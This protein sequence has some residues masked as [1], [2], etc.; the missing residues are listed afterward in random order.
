MGSNG[1]AR[2]TAIGVDI[3]GTTTKAGIVTADGEIL[4]RV[5]RP[6]DPSAAT[7]GAIACVDDLLE[8]ATD[9]EI[10]ACGVGAAGFV[11]GS[12]VIFSPNLTFDDPQVGAALEARTQLPV[13]VDNDANAAV[14]GERTF[15]VATGKDNVAMVTIGTGIGSGFIV[16]GRLLHGSSG[17]AAEIGHTVVDPS[18]PT[19]ECGLKGCLEQFASGLAIARWARDAVTTDPKSSILTFAGSVEQITAEHVGKAAKEYDETARAVLRRAGLALGVGLSN[20]ANIFDPEVIVLA[21]SVTRA[22]EA[23]L[24]PARDELAR[25]TGAQRR[26]PMRLE[27]SALEGNA[28][29][30]GAAT[31]ALEAA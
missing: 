30:L 12:T 20:I 11:G 13:T 28:G 10:V 26:R 1:A 15:G 17:A 31:L 8:R 4:V 27:L 9:V 6:T 23:F 29:I 5:D 16:D 14:W 22:G 7:K 25:M 21:G 2:R 3:G 19:C 24:G 18:G